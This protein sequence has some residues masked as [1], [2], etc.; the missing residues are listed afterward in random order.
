M[1]AQG[2]GSSG[3]AVSVHGPAGV[4][5]LLVPA[6]ASVVDV[7]RE[8]AARSGLDSL[9]LLYT[10]LGSPLRADVALATAGVGSG[11]LLVAATSLHRPAPEVRAPLL[12]RSSGEPGRISVLWFTLAAVVAVLSGWCAATS[13]S[14]EVRRLAVGVLVGA[15]AIGVLPIGRYAPSRALAAPAFGAAAGLNAAWAP[16]PEGL[17]LV[18]GIAGLSAAVTAAVARSLDQHVEEGLRV[19]MIAGGAL[20]VVT[21]LAAVLQLTAAVTWSV[22]LV[23]AMLAARF[24][25][26]FAVDVPD[27][28][29]IDLER[30]AVTAW[31]ARERPRGRRGRAVASPRAVELVARRGTRFVAAACVAIAVVAVV[32]AAL[33]LESVTHDLDVIGARCLVLASGAGLLLAGRSY[34]HAAARALL[35]TA[36]LGCWVLITADVLAAAGTTLPSLLA[37]GSIVLAAALIVAAVATGRGWRSVWWSRRAEVAEGL[38]GAVALASVLVASG[39]FRTAWEFGS[40]VAP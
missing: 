17:P 35:R 15:A 28:L 38:A 32:A 39:W 7:A 11:D 29:L 19:W 34:R 36:G 13:G 10:R 33:V 6:G 24:V 40:R 5:D 37:A 1:T 21:G 8:Y 26:G 14:D 27:Q 23:G 16:Q 31:S 22:L 3:L 25:P 20:F 30:L 18:L 2:A 4:L 12:A 9:P